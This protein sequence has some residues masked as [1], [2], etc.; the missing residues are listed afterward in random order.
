MNQEQVEAIPIAVIV[1]LS[2]HQM[3]PFA[4]LRASSAGTN[5]GLPEY[6][7]PDLVTIH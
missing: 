6:E 5:A 2:K 7:L 4:D 1:W 3:K